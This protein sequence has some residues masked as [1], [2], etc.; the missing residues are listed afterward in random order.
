MYFSFREEDLGTKGKA[1]YNG[2]SEVEI[3]QLQ[4]RYSLVV[5]LGPE[6]HI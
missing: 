3:M 6:V 1:L 2:T 5:W 4:A